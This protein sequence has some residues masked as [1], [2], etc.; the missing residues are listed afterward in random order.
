MSLNEKPTETI[1]P[2]SHYVFIEKIGPFQETARA[3]WEEF[4][5]KVG[6]LGKDKSFLSVTS[7][8]KMKPQM[9]YRAGVMLKAMPA[10]I[11]KG[12]RY[13]KFSGGKYTRFTLT[14]SYSQLPEA[15]GKVFSIV[16][17]TALPLREDFFI[18]NYVNDPKTTLESDLITEIM[19]PTK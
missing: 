14:G 9:I 12:L 2:E 4:H 19:M 16:E 5:Q 15:C 10:L 1:W 18:E 13:E 6:E 7:L 11:P 17:R 8:Y 3:A